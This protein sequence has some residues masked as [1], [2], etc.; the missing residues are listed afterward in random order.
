M[1]ND[2]N[3]FIKRNFIYL[4]KQLLNKF[5]KSFY[6]YLLK[7][8]NFYFDIVGQ[9]SKKPL[10]INFHLLQFLKLEIYQKI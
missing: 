5:L 10:K 4:K 9:Y 3:V 6:E 7:I 8:T 1:N 2:F